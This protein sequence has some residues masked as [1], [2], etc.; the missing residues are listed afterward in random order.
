MP[1]NN[2][3]SSRTLA[4]CA[5]V[6]MNLVAAGALLIN[7]CRSRIEHTYAASMTRTLTLAVL[8]YQVEVGA[9]PDCLPSL[10]QGTS[11]GALFSLP[12]LVASPYS[13]R[14]E[15]VLDMLMGNCDYILCV[16]NLQEH[17]AV[18]PKRTVIVYLRPG[19][20][21]TWGCAG[22]LDGHTEEWDSELP[23]SRLFEGHGWTTGS[24]WA[25]ASASRSR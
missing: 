18:D 2:R 5:L 11:H 7:H 23:I 22:F 1:R 12:T 10:A 20:F 8:Q 15:T 21:R 6:A 24:K 13:S 14:P 9:Y 17:P 3:W 25:N 4:I 16:D 19:I